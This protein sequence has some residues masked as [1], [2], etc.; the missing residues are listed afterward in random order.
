VGCGDAP[1]RIKDG[2]TID[3]DGMAGT[4]SLK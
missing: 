1:R 4:V 3:V 2:Q